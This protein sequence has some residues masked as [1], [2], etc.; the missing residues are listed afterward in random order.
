MVDTPQRAE[1]RS[2]QRAEQRAEQRPSQQRM[3]RTGE[4]RFTHDTSLQPTNV[5]YEWKRV[6]IWGK[7]DEEHQINMRN[8]GWTPVPA[9]RHPELSLLTPS[10]D[11]VI[12]RGGQMLMERPKELTAQA[13]LED[14]TRA[15]EQVMTQL[16]RVGHESRQRGFDKTK[17]SHEGFSEIPRG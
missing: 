6:S 16:Q 8:N 15:Q 13:R 4:N 7:P 3:V 9:N 2:E 10:K 12:V 14:K 1:Q 17:V 5:T 11:G